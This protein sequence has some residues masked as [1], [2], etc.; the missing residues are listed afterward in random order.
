MVEKRAVLLLDEVYKSQVLS[1]EQRI[2]ENTVKSS[3]P[4]RLQLDSHNEVSHHRQRP[5]LCL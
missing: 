5:C 2:R 3:K 4:T 1:P